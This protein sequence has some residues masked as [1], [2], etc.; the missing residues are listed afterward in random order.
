MKGGRMGTKNK[1]IERYQSEIRKTREKIN[2][3][4]QHLKKLLALLKKEEDM[5]MV[6]SL[7]SRGI[8][9]ESLY[10]LLNGIQDGTIQFYKDGKP[11]KASKKE[12]ADP[13]GKEE[14]GE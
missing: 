10:D 13:E 7:R 2:D 1:K 12:H 11:I 6:K 8:D 5:E 9:G 4:Q 14:R 3:L